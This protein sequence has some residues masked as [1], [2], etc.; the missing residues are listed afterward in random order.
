MK[1]LYKTDVVTMILGEASRLPRQGVEGRAF[2][3][4]NI[5]LCKYW[6]KRN[7][8]LNLP[9]TSSLS[10]SLHQ[11]GTTTTIAARTS[12]SGDEVLL[13]GQPVAGGQPFARGV[14]D[15]LNLFR[16]DPHFFYRVDTRNTIPT[17]AGL[18]SSASGFAALTLALNQLCAW[19]LEPRQLSILARL[20]SGSASRSIYQGFAEWQAG[21]DADGMDSFAVPVKGTWPDLRLGLVKVSTAEKAVSSRAA[22]KRTVQTSAL[23]E[24]WPAKV[25][26]DLLLIKEAIAARDFTQLGQTAESNALAMHA[27]GLA[28]WPPV[29]FWL[30]ESVAVL[31]RTWQLREQGLPL[32]ITMDAGPN[33]KLLFQA[34]DTATVQ[35]HFPA[36]DVVTPFP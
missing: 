26:R 21:T 17:A 20:G 18:A 14:T 28:A 12:G 13:N 31:H 29:L 34:A 25:A 32:Y 19:H 15:F 8:E 7:D 9:V 10:V 23:Y 35:R 16:P 5:A 22:M 6:G 30:P 11:L 27:T 1:S 4:S 24:A 3:P 2:A 33:V 36:V